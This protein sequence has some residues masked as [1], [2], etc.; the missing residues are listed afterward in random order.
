MSVSTNL[1]IGL[2]SSI[3]ANLIMSSYH[4]IAWYRKNYNQRIFRWFYGKYN[5]R[6]ICIT[7]STIKNLDDVS[8]F[9]SKRIFTHIG[10]AQAVT[11]VQELLSSRLL[12]NVLILPN[13]TSFIPHSDVVNIGGPAFNESTFNLIKVIKG[14]YRLPF[15]FDEGPNGWFI[16]G[17]IG[18]HELIMNNQR[19][20]VQDYALIAK[21]PHPHPSSPNKNEAFSIMLA[22][23]SMY[24]TLGAASFI[25]DINK[26]RKLNPD[27]FSSIFKPG[28]LLI[29]LFYSLGI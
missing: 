29:R 7:F 19:E 17:E 11:K 9:R 26:L 12:K 25:T 28:W 1:L 21:L 3:L 15:N 5:A 6:S 20:V 8:K 24:G 18:P 2:F 4:L 10:D 16:S 22:G 14:N 13:Q 27:P 23:L